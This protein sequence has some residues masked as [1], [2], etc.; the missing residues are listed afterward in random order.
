MRTLGQKRAEFALKKVLAAKDVKDFKNF[1]AGAPSMVLKNGF[2]QAL[3]FWLAKGK[4]GDKQ[5]KLFDIVREWMSYN[6]GKDITNKF[7]K[8]SNNR[9]DFIK[10]LSEME[11]VDYLKA[12]T[13]TL[14]LLEWVKRYANADL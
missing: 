4:D 14:K 6:N 5:Y 8:S 12:Q 11:Q 2:G 7:V 9:T 10:N 13:E 3:A 1:T